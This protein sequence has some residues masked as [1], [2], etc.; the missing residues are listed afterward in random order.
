MGAKAGRRLLHKRAA[1]KMLAQGNQPVG[2]GDYVGA[3]ENSARRT[4]R[5]RARRS[6]STSGPRCGSRAQRGGRGLR[7]LPRPERDAVREKDVKRVLG[8]IDAVMW[9]PRVT[10][11]DPAAAGRQADRAVR[12]RGEPARRAGEHTVMAEKDG[13]ALRQVQ[14]VIVWPG[15]RHLV[16]LRFAPPPPPPAPPPSNTQRTLAS[17]S[18]VW[19]A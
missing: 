14:S 2:E 1:Q 5:F 7:E 15:R 19:A 17:R 18:A 6:C 11:D 4:D 16:Q 9:A 8:E 13:S 12:E 10:V 3:L